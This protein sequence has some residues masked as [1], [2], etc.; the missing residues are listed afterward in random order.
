MKPVFSYFPEEGFVKC[1]LKKIREI[2][3]LFDNSMSPR[4]REMLARKRTAN[5]MDM[6][7]AVGIAW[8]KDYYW[9]IIS[10][11]SKQEY[12]Y[13][14]IMEYAD[15][16]Y[17]PLSNKFPSFGSVQSLVF[18][19]KLHTDRIRDHLIKT[20]V[21]LGKDL[22]ST[23]GYYLCWDETNY[24]YAYKTNMPN[25]SISEALG[26]IEEQNNPLKTKQNER[27]ENRNSEI[28]SLYRKIETKGEL[29]RKGLRVP[30]RTKQIAST[31]RLVGNTTRACKSKKTI[32]RGTLKR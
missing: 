9:F 17:Y 32:G 10:G 28:N 11:S 22:R 3:A 30:Q 31:K 7:E 14:K 12:S 18:G 6:M 19:L 23:D 15:S 4:G 5:T 1:N 16:V 24:W 20:R 27:K 13:K 8:N 21:L 25:Y 26:F 2:V 29:I